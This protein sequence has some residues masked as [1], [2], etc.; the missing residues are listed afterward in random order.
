MLFDRIGNVG[1]LS[2]KSVATEGEDPTIKTGAS[3]PTHSRLD[4]DHTSDVFIGGAPDTYQV[5]CS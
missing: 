3:P 4:L 5:N 1:R 2:V